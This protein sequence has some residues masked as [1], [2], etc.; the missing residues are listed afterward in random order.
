MRVRVRVR[1]REGEEVDPDADR[2]RPASDETR[3]EQGKRLAA[4]LAATRSRHFATVS[5]GRDVAGPE[6]SR[7][8]APPP[9]SRLS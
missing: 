1:P 7:Y 8:F 3:A 4:T 6:H 9:M 2:A 5:D